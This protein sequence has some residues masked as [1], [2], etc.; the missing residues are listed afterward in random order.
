[1]IRTSFKE[2]KYSS[3]NIFTI[4]IF[5]IQVKF[6]FPSPLGYPKG[7]IIIIWQYSLLNFEGYLINYKH[8]TALNL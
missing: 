5:L 1:M 6:A 4:K 8:V 7:P 2:I 3:V